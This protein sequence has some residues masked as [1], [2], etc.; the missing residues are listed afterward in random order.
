MKPLNSSLEVGLR[1]LLI[2]QN[3]FPEHLDLNQLVLLDHSVLHSADLGG[4]ES[5]HPPVPVRASELGVKRQA[6]EAGL[7]VMIRAHLAH[8]GVGDGGIEFWAGEAAD[9]FIKLLE[10][11]YA[12]QLST[13]AA[14][15]VQHFGTLDEQT[16]R[17][18]LS[19]VAQHWSEEFA[20]AAAPEELH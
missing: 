8:V 15:V 1:V 14:W 9:G 17:A 6:I 3:A 5:L 12:A 13:R 4:P 18:A 19:T 10:T 11:E 2:L 20:T 16:L 7:E